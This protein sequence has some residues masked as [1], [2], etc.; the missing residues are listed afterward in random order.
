MLYINAMIFKKQ[1]SKIQNGFILTKNG[2]IEKVGDMDECPKGEFN[3]KDLSGYAVYPGFIDAHSHIGMW[4]DGLDFEGD[5]G[6]ED[7]DP[8]SPQLRAIDAVNPMDACFKEALD[9]GVTTVITGPGSANPI[10]GSWVAMKT[11]GHCVDDMVI[12]DSVGIKF[13]LGENPKNVYNEKGQAPVTRMGIAALIREQLE[14]ARRYKRDLERAKT[15]DCDEPEFDVKCESLIKLL[16]REVK[17]L[18][19][20]HRADDIYTAIRISKEFNLDLVLVHATEGYLI[21]ES[22]KGMD[23]ISGPIICDRS[24]PELRN[25]RVSNSLKLIE[26]GANVAICTDHPVVP[27]QYN[28]LSCAVAIREGLTREQAINSITLAPAKICGIA[29]KVGSIEPGKHADFVVFNKNDDIFSP[30]VKPALVVVYG[31]VVVKN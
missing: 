9:A 4:E 14:K 12:K 10:G 25:Q 5:D 22:L 6:N 1:G 23:I 31:N 2:I 19:H 3:C 20:C 17:A 27:I 29:D 18:F 15:H 7:T 16:N 8:I 30:F 13:A 11:L 21:S 26:H 24:K 28:L